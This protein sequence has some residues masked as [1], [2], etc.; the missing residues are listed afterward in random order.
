MSKLVH[1]GGSPGALGE[2]AAPDAGAAAASARRPRR[3]TDILTGVL[4][5]VAVGVVAVS[6]SPALLRAAGVMDPRPEAGAPQG[7]RFALFPPERERPS[8]PLFEEEDEDDVSPPSLERDHPEIPWLDRRSSP[9]RAG[10]R[11]KQGASAEDDGPRVHELEGPHGGAGE[12]RARIG[13]ARRR[14]TLVEHP[15]EAG[16]KVGEIQSGKMVMVLKEVGDFALVAYSSEDGVV[17]GWTKKSE[18]AVR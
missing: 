5:S 10:E 11:G 16:P 14:I 2:G 18:I 13:V 17:M 3:W 4:L 12:T 6:A 15:G 7:G 8:R 1:D 9:G